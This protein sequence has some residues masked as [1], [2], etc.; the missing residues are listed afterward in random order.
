[1]SGRDRCGVIG[2]MEPDD[3]KNG[4]TTPPVAQTEQSAMPGVEPE[5]SEAELREMRDFLDGDFMALLNLC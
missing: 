4:A 5:F 3:S 2:A 1:L